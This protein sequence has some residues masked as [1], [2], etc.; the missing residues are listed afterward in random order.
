MNIYITLD[1]ELY[2][3]RKTG[4]PENGLFR[5]MSAI[6]DMLDKTGIKLTVFVDGA[7][8][9][10]MSELK[11][12]CQS[13]NKDLHNVTMNIK[14]ISER[15]HS[16]QYHFHPQWLYSTYE[17]E[18]GWVM[19]MNH[20]KLSDVPGD[21]LSIAFRKGKEIIEKIIGKKI[22]AFRAGG[23]SLCSYLCYG[24][25]FNNNGIRID[26]S[27]LPG[28][29]E[30]SK[31]QEYDYRKAPLKSSYNFREDVCTELMDE[32]DAFVEI[33]ITTIPGKIN[34]CY[35]INYTFH[36]FQKEQQSISEPVVV[37]GDGKSVSTEISRIV[38]Y[39]K[40]FKALFRNGIT[41]ANLD[42]LKGSI[43]DA[44]TRVSQSNQNQLVI[45]GHPKAS[46]NL[47][48]KEL[49]RFIDEKLI[50]GDNFLTFDNVL[51]Y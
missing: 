18:K 40:I 42:S 47:S 20:Y 51:N 39:W 6:M 44:Y 29:W 17:E 50:V 8:L 28:L 7:Y 11:D 15:G 41:M 2:L 21:K 4:T 27:V 24:S 43:Y 5:P 3:G 31:F 30:R 26:S 12:N 34:I 45:I 48:I 33:P 37:Y 9:Y 25:L 38:K 46:S 35:W 49:E 32:K 10:R 14:E 36:K 19:D 22:I 1:Y 16:V 13:I 23:Y